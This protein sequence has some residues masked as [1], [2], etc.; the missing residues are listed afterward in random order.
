[1]PKPR[2]LH[3]GSTTVLSTIL[4]L[5]GVAMIVRTL[6]AGGGGLAFGLL[7]GV[8][9][10]AAGLGRMYINGLLGRRGGAGRER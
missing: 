4:V 10:I 5:L 9:F 6:A 8:L 7:L 3:R 2:D 1:M